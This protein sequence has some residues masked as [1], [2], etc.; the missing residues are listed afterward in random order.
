M[1]PPRPLN[2]EERLQKLEKE[3]AEIRAELEVKPQPVP[4]Y[5]PE[6]IRRYREMEQARE[7]DRDI[8]DRSPIDPKTDEV[9]LT[10]GHKARASLRILAAMGTKYKMPCSVCAREWLAKAVEAESKNHE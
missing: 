4:R 1:K 10:C 7:F 3:V 8:T 6:V 9:T 2:I 5:S